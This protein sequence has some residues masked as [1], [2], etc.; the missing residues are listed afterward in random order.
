MSYHELLKRELYAT[1]GMADSSTA[2][3][4]AIL[5]RTPVDYSP[6]LARAAPGAPT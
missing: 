3:A 5:R 2:A 1:A 6:D 4:E